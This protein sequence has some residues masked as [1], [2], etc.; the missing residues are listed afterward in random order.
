MAK[1]KLGLCVAQISSLPIPRRRLGVAARHTLPKIEQL[2]EL[3]LRLSK[4]LVRGQPIPTCSF[5]IASRRALALA[6]HQPK[7]VLRPREM[8]VRRSLAPRER[9][10]EV[11]GCIVAKAEI[12]LR[13]RV[14]LLSSPALPAGCLALILRYTLARVVHR[15]EHVLRLGMPLLGCDP[16]RRC[17]LGKSPGLM[18]R[19]T[20][21]ILR[22]RSRASRITTPPRDDARAPRMQRNRRPS[23]NPLQ[24]TLRLHLHARLIVHAR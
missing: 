13:I 6:V 1:L 8:A 18:V 7:V 3:L 19:G 24:P 2:G 15:A 23:G 9:L 4:V 17:S 14:P 5:R 11:T 12:G 16:K 21:L 10:Q 20:L 22:V